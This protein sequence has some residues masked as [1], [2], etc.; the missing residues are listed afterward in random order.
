VTP[1]E[2]D[3]FER[4]IERKIRGLEIELTDKVHERDRYAAGCGHKASLREALDE[5]RRRRAGKEEP[6][7]DEDA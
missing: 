7:K 2:L 5:L 1:A 6:E 4:F 3:D